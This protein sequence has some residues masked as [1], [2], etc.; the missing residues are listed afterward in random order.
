[1]G[2]FLAVIGYRY[3]YRVYN[4]EFTM[5]L[6]ALACKVRGKGTVTG[7]VL[8]N[9]KPFTERDFRH[10]GVYVMQAEPLLATATVQPSS[11]MPLEQNCL[12]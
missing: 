6:N 2:P 4:V 5:Q 10:W 3:A 1:V 8:V 11:A 7:Q 9:G 12:S